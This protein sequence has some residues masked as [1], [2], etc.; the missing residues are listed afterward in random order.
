[1][2]LEKLSNMFFT[3]VAIDLGTANTLIYIRGKG[4]VL[5]EPS[6]VTVR[7]IRGRKVVEAV[8]EEA[9]RMQGKTPE[10]VVT[11]R[12]LRDGVVA[13]FEVAEAM[14]KYFMKKVVPTHFLKS[15]LI[16]VSVPSGATPVE[17][18]AIQES[19]ESAGAR[20]VY[21]IEEPMAAAIGADLPVNDPSGLMI[22]D[23]GG[24]T[25]EVAV[26]SLGGLVYAASLRVAGDRMNEA[27]IDYVRRKM[28]MV[29][30][31]AT[32]EIIKHNIGTAW[33]TKKDPIQSMKI[34]GRKVD[35]GRLLEE[36][37]DENQVADALQEPLHQIAEAIKKAMEA[38]PPELAA[39]LVDRGIML[40]GGG[41]LLRN[42]ARY[43]SAES[44][45]SV[46]ISENP[47]ECV[48]RGAGKALEDFEKYRSVLI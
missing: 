13:D 18:R 38:T 40:T 30:G 35:E 44:G 39:D 7:D 23:I 21:L 5:N 45:L 1:M 43:I 4:I 33:H 47:L 24:G 16:V 17:R 29:I 37:I 28:R 8:G 11:I 25:T 26:I 36:E 31:E 42:I 9:K 14:I 46:L 48:V 10:D 22:V 19:V 20:R 2:F 6:I 27:I 15:P 41:A 12:P 32:A 34:K 3:D